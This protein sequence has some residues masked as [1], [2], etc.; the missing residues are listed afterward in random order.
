MTIELEPVDFYCPECDSIL[1]AT[2]CSLTQ[3]SGYRCANCEAGCDVDIPD[4]ACE[5]AS[6]LQTYLERRQRWA[7]LG[8]RRDWPFH[9]GECL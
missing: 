1:D 9:G 6:R 5:K 2:G 3:C 7:W 8:A 4:G